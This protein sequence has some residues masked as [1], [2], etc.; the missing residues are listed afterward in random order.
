M[1]AFLLDCREDERPVNFPSKE[2][3]S[4]VLEMMAS[5]TDDAI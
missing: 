2:A 3:S 1:A 5:F 4:L